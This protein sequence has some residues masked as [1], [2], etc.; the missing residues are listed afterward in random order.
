MLDELE[1][2]NDEVRG[3]FPSHPH[4]GFST[5]TILKRGAVAHKDSC[6][7]KGIITAG[8]CQW[9]IAGRGVVHSE[10]PI[11]DEEGR[12][13]HGFQL[14]VN[15][16]A[17]LKMMK[18]RYQDMKSEDFGVVEPAPGVSVR[19]MAGTAHGAKGPIAIPTGE[20]LFLD[21]TVQPG[22]TWTLDDIPASWNAF[23][24]PYRGQGR[25]SGAPARA[26]AVHVLET[27]P[28]AVKVEATGSA[29]MEA[30]VLAGPP[31]GEPI[32]QYG[33]FVM[34]SELEIRQA[35]DDYH[36]GALQ[37]PND[38]VWAADDA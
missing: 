12:G 8:G 32:V 3:G 30:L 16:P 21:A 33:P 38:D 13:L 29:P 4:R 36:S 26:R 35:F 14:W 6:G 27:G 9:M 22:A 1:G 17:K 5:V 15:L 10:M 37:N 25:I 24:Y 31:I 34:N 7:N 20:F 11:A 19:P 28:G 2:T 23:I 18:P